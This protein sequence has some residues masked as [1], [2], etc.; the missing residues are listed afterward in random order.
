MLSE[1]SAIQSVMFWILIHAA[2]FSFWI[3]RDSKSPPLGIHQNLQDINL[4]QQNFLF[5]YSFDLLEKSDYWTKVFH[6]PTS[7]LAW[8]ISL[9]L[10]TFSFSQSFLRSLSKSKFMA[11]PLDRQLKFSLSWNICLCFSLSAKKSD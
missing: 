9:L 7:E 8:D 10:S 6:S 3:T 11:C 2:K 1:I 4:T 5:R